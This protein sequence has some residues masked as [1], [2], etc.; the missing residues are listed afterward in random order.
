MRIIVQWSLVAVAVAAL[1]TTGFQCSSAELTSAK[2]YLQRKDYVNAQKQL[3]K[4]IEKNPKSEEAYFILGKDVHFELKD[5]KGMKESFD[6]ALAISQVHQK[7]I[8]ML[9][10]SAWGRLFNEGVDAINKAS[11]SSAN[12]DKAITAFTTA[13]TVLPESLTTRRNL[14]L[15]YYR[16]GDNVHAAE[17][18]L[19]AFEQGKDVL[20]CH[21]LGRLYLDQGNESR[22]KFSDAHREIFASL[23]NLATLHE[24]MKPVDVKYLLGNPAEVGKPAKAKKNDTK[25]EWKY[26]Q[27]N[28]TV[29]VEGDAVTALKYS[30]PY[31]P[32]VDSTEYYSS[33][34]SFN[35]AV[36]VMKK[37]QAMFPE[38]GEI[39]ENLMNAYIGASRND[40]ARLLLMERVKKYPTSKFDHY[41]L[42]VFLLKDSSYSAAVD[43]FKTTITLDSAFSAAVYNIAATF[44]NWGV[45]EQEKVKASN[46][47]AREQNKPEDQSYKEKFRMA[48]PYLEKIVGEKKDDVQMWEL[49]GQVYANLNIQDKAI[50]A[51]DIADLARTLKVGTVKADVE[52]IL[53]K[54]DKTGDTVY[55]GKGSQEYIYTAK[56][57]HVYLR[58]DKVAGFTVVK[59]KK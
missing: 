11:D 14:G 28:L 52:Q 12:V 1:L 36:E 51:Y 17:N 24:K 30:S 54:P 27:Y 42:G 37:G 46:E 33:L 44:V 19:I 23:R 4:E 22:M 25:E 41:N 18:L 48:L 40:E 6:K 20:A 31:S 47:K 9:E 26:P 58:D 2:L 56:G 21:V 43:E 5:F 8:H 57:W 32:K 16:K 13:L 15:A 10:V 3:E 7:E 55:D 39:S 59:E 34:A 38:D 35:K 50:Q 29:S 49:L 53:G 45:A